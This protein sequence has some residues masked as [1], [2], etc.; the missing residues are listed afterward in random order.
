M[1][2]VFFWL[3]KKLKNKKNFLKLFFTT[4]LAWNLPDICYDVPLFVH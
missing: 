2:E 1:K 3:K 4:I